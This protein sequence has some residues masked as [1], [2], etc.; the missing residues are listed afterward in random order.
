MTAPVT[1]CIGPAESGSLMS[2]SYREGSG[3]L[4][5]YSVT[6]DMLQTLLDS[7]VP[8][9]ITLEEGQEPVF[10]AEGA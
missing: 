10:A 1:I 7:E 9:T 3:T 8:A 6:K 4:V 5:V 2:V